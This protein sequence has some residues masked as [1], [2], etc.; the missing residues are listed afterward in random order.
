MV[1]ASGGRQLQP[2]NVNTKCS[3]HEKIAEIHFVF[4][5]NTGPC[6]LPSDHSLRFSTGTTSWDTA[7]DVSHDFMRFSHLNLQGKVVGEDPLAV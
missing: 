3:L 5:T 4:I 2:V 1:Y 6:R 7:A